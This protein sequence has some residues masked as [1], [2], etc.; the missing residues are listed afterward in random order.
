MK[1][2]QAKLPNLPL[3]FWQKTKGVLL[4][5]CD[6]MTDILAVHYNN[7]YWQV[8]DTQ[9]NT[10]FL[11]SAYFD[12]RESSLRQNLA[13]KGKMSYNSKLFKSGYEPL[14]WWFI[15]RE[16]VVKKSGPVIRV[17]GMIKHNIEKENR[18]F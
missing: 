10:L 11:Y 7:D 3:L 6:K 5:R 9:H 14:Q 1:K 17:L 16:G 4:S 8:L 18:E 15:N 2:L 13:N 12:N